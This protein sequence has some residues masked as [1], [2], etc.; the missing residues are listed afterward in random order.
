MGH[1]WVQ[2]GPFAPKKHFWGKI[3]NNILIYL[4]TNFIVPDFKIFLQQT[5][6]YEDVLFLDT[7]WANLPKLKYF[8][9]PVDKPSLYHPCLSTF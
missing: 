3:I 5:Q 6:S 2:N 4:L 1:F 7:K 9:K 8:Q